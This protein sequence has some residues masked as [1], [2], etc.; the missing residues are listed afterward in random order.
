MSWQAT[1]VI[2]PTLLAVR[3]TAL[4]LKAAI[5][6][7]GAPES[8]QELELAFVEACTN[9][10]RHGARGTGRGDIQVSIEIVASQ[11][12]IVIEDGGNPFNPF[13]EERVIDVNDIASLPCGGYGLALIRK[14]CDSVEYQHTSRGN[15]L[16]LTKLM[17]P[18]IPEKVAMGSE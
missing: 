3:R 8:R 17:T 5:A 6:D 16:A 11:V 2:E 15:R 13:A 18:A 14:I 10:A 1:I 9:S 4:V 7:I 12:A